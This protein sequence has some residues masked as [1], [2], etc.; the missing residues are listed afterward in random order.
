M[1]REELRFKKGKP[2]NSYCECNNFVTC[3]N[4]AT[5]GGHNHLFI[6]NII[7][8]YQFSSIVIETYH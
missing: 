2:T 5:A 4:I 3:Y 8:N 1:G 6:L 7:T